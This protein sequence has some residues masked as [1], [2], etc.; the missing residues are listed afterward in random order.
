MFSNQDVGHRMR[1][2]NPKIEISSRQ[3]QPKKW[4]QKPLAK[5]QAGRRRIAGGF[6]EERAACLGLDGEYDCT[7]R[8]GDSTA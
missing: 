5:R 1:S 7:L 4:L 6:L 2:R 3:K 8:A